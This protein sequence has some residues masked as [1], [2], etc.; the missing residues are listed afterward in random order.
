MIRRPPR[1]TLFPYTTLFRSL[2]RGPAAARR[3]DGVPAAPRVEHPALHLRP[4][5]G[6]GLGVRARLVHQLAQLS[7]LVR[8][9]VTQLPQLAGQPTARARARLGREQ[10]TDR[11]PAG[12]PEQ[13]PAEPRAA[14]GAVRTAVTLAH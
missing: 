14:P 1:S 13:E 3:P 6:H 2:G 5:C 8:R 11:R 7:G 9:E 10:E 12:P 4:R